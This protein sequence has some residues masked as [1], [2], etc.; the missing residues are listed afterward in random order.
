MKIKGLIHFINEVNDSKASPCPYNRIQLELMKIKKSFLKKKMKMYSTKKCIAKL[1]YIELFGCHV[2]F[3]FQQIKSL[4]KSR[5]LSDNF[6]GW[7]ATII[8]IGNDRNLI[9]ELIPEMRR[10]L[11]STGNE[12]GICFTLNAISAIECSELADSIGPSIAD[13]VILPNVSEF[14]RKKAIL[15]L[16]R[17]Y[18]ISHQFPAIDR[19]TPK[20]PSLLASKSFGIRQCAS[21]LVMT[22]VQNQA[23][24]INDV[25][26]IIITQMN[27]IYVKNENP[28]EIIRDDVPCPF[29]VAKQLQILCSKSDWEDDEVSDMEKILNSLLDKFS[30]DNIPSLMV[31]YEAADMASSAPFSDS[32]VEKIITHL[33]SLILDKNSY[34]QVFALEKLTLIVHSIPHCASSVQPSLNVLLELV[35]KKDHYIDI[36]A[37]NLL[38][39]I[40]N[41]ENGLILVNKLLEFLPESPLYL[42]ASLCLKIAVLVQSYEQNDLNCISTLL[43]LLKKGNN[44]ENNK[45]CRSIAQIVAQKPEL[46]VHVTE[47]VYEMIKLLRQPQLSNIRLVSYLL[48][49]YCENCEISTKEAI[50]LLFKFYD[51]IDD[52]SE[53]ETNNFTESFDINSNYNNFIQFNNNYNS[54][55]T[56]NNF[57]WNDYQIYNDDDY[58]KGRVKSTILTALF[59]FGSKLSINQTNSQSNTQN[60]NQNDGLNSNLN[61]ELNNGQGCDKRNEILEFFRNRAGTSNFELAQRCQEYANILNLPENILSKL[62]IIPNSSLMNG[63]LTLNEL[64]TSKINTTSNETISTEEYNSSIEQIYDPNINI[65]KEFE[66]TDTGVLLANRNFIIRAAV[67]YEQ[68]RLNMIINIENLRNDQIS[69]DL[70]DIESTEE[71]LFRIGDIPQNIEGG[72][73]SSIAVDFVMMEMTDKLPTLNVTI[74]K[75]ENASSPLPVFFN[76]WM[77][78][79]EV[80]KDSFFSRW[81]TITDNE[82]T[83]IVQLMIPDGDVM[84]ET[85]KIMK[86]SLGLDPF[87]FDIPQN[88]L[89]S[90][91]AFKCFKVNIGVLLRFVY[92]EENLNLTLQVKANVKSAIKYICDIAHKAFLS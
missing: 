67:R 48:G 73:R 79:F 41:N 50:D 6:F 39:A 69:I 13:I 88:N 64:F 11:T 33:L 82:L 1:C 71:L 76:K 65:F 2:T 42:R 47:E 18:Q 80:D 75:T 49:E 54:G 85:A 10:F 60:N 84:K 7:L 63:Q 40:A 14:A 86:K 46:Q 34:M 56:N 87:D 68:P 16:N 59:K 81:A 78:Q 53:G 23:A 62:I 44:F 66:N 4:L 83:G 8:L 58:D 26:P 45:I 29:L 55:F 12:M 20:L 30:K 5:D 19:V 21:S 31:L 91:G 51:D 35:K 72:E 24:S 61:N 38:Y 9:K 22:I 28:K 43:T 92:D 57:I 25:F 89:I 52:Y 27:K 37:L 15:T 36:R 74:N 3:G 70:F 77:T 17:I 90:A 32:M